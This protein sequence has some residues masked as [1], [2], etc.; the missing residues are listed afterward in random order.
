MAITNYLTLKQAVQ[1]WLGRDDLAN[2]ITEFISLAESRIARSLRVQAMETAADLTITSGVADQPDGYLETIRIYLDDASRTKLDYM[3]PSVFWTRNAVLETNT[4]K[5]Y[6][7]EDQK[8]K[9]APLGSDTGKLLYYKKFDALSSNSDTN[10]IITNAPGLLLYGALLEA[11]LFLEDDAGV[12]KYAA[13]FDN[14][15]GV[16]NMEDRNA[17][18][19]RGGASTRS[20]VSVV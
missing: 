16:L 1:N 7:I 15:L 8:F 20:E 13:L 19:P 12:N 18:Y 17:R 9:F 2:R 5:I 10:W 6:T 14:L 11:Y 4:P 3:S